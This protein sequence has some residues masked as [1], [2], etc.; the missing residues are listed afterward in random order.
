M[1]EGGKSLEARSVISSLIHIVLTKTNVQINDEN[2]LHL[3]DTAMGTKI[4]PYYASLLMCKLETDF[5]GSCS[6]MSFS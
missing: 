6:L 2:Y 1:S 4:S 5:L 3:L